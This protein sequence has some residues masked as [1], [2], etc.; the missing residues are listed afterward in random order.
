M[1]AP[2]TATIWR[3]ISPDRRTGAPNRPGR[4]IDTLHRDALVALPRAKSDSPSVAT[5][6]NP[7][8]SSLEK[9]VVAPE[10]GSTRTSCAV[11][12]PP[13]DPAIHIA[14]AVA[15]SPPPPTSQVVTVG[16]GIVSTIDIDVG[17]T[18]ESAARSTPS[19]PSMPYAVTH[20]LPNPA[21]SAV[22]CPVGPT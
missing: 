9:V 10:I 15:I 16:T 21:V 19:P 11:C 5:S 2:G 14:S 4:G 13:P 8:R 3:P 1:T 17:S 7:L 18:P 6:V 22:V 12:G 20:R